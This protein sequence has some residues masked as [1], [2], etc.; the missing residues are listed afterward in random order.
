MKR[1]FALASLILASLFLAS[2]GWFSGVSAHGSLGERRATDLADMAAAANLVVVAEIARVDYRNTPIKGEQGTIPTSLVTIKVVETLR[3]AAPKA[4]LTVRFL[5]GPDGRGGIAGFSG[6]PMFVAGETNIL[7]IKANGDASCPLTNCEWGRFRVFKGAVYDTHG[8]PVTGIAKG[9]VVAHGR[10]RKELT[11]FR[12]PRPSFDAVLQHSFV[13]ERLAKS[14]MSLQEAR[15]RYEREAPP[16]IVYSID[17]AENQESPDP[18]DDPMPAGQ[19]AGI[20]KQIL[21]QPTVTPKAPMTLG[22]FVAALKPIMA[23]ARRQPSPV[24]SANLAPDFTLP[25]IRKTAPKAP[26][27]SEA[28]AAN[29]EEADNPL[30]GQTNLNKPQ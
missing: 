12:F 1:R 23:T 11:V 15:A 8:A 18:T 30:A 14:G 29:K 4:P 2:V 26:T 25:G 17:F 20:V 9:H 21:R 10:P 27:V 3:G 13:K 6:V 7:F 5:G 22:A 24:A 19:G 28:P 16:F